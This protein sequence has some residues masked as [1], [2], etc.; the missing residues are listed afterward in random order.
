MDVII[1]V[2]WKDAIMVV[3][4]IYFYSFILSPLYTYEIFKSTDTPFPLLAWVPIATDPQTSTRDA[5]NPP[6][7]KP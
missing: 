4:F 2:K 5:I 7:K 3:I 1:P 6:C